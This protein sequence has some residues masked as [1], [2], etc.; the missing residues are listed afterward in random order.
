M[1]SRAFCLL[2]F[3]G[4]VAATTVFPQQKDTSKQSVE[5]RLGDVQKEKSSLTVEKAIEA[6][7]AAGSFGQVALSPDGKRIAWVEK[8]RNKEG[9]ET[10]KST[11]FA[12]SAE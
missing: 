2:L 4:F 11:I 6:L 3:G 8:L 10:G 5:K 7:A 9:V 1:K 12:A